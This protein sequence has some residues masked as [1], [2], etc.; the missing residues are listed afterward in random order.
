MAA[1]KGTI[2]LC[3]IV[4]DEEKNLARCLKSALGYVDEIIVVDTG[5]RDATPDIAKSYGAVV[6]HSPWQNDFSQARNESIK[7]AAGEWVLILDADEELPAETAHKLRDLARAP[8]VE[9]WT[10]TIVS[11]VLSRKDGPKTKHLNLRMFRNKDIYRFEGK[12]HEQVKPSILR[13]NPGAVIE[14]SNLAIIHYGYVRD[15]GERRAKTRRNIAILEEA[16]ASNPADPFYHYN[17]GV[18]YFTLGDLKSS[19]RHYETALQHADLKAGFAAVLYRNYCLCLYELGEYAETL[20]TADKALIYFADY[21]DLYFI[22]G[23]VFCDLGMLPE[24]KASFLKCT[25][26]RKIPPEYTTMEGVTSYLAFENLAEICALE[27]NWDEAVDHITRAIEHQ[28]S[29]RLLSRLC[30]LLQKKNYQGN[31]IA[32]YLLESLKIK[33]QTAARILFD[34]QEFEACLACIGDTPAGSE[35]ALLKA[36]CLIRLGHY[37]KAAEALQKIHPRCH[38]VVEG[39]KQKSLTAWLRNPR[40]DAAMPASAGNNPGHPATVCCQAINSL[41]GSTATLQQQDVREHALDIALEALRL[42]DR[43]LSMMISLTVT[44]HKI[45]EAYRTLG[46]YV[47]QKGCYAEAKEL[48]KQALN[49]GSATKEIYYLLGTACANLNLHGKAFGY[50]LEAFKQAPENELFA[51]CALQSLV[52]ECLAFVIN[53]LNLEKNNAVLRQELFRLTSL[54]RKLQYCKEAV[55]SADRHSQPLHDCQKRGR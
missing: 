2:S 38:L 23:Q 25:R 36:K 49:S 9:A 47:L 33:R 29:Y 20:A 6:V 5:S 54:K 32:A 10:F 13:H 14:Y 44:G 45:Q 8:G 22:K 48:L 39:L 21:P 4:R 15:T 1:N 50:F 46:E 27:G 51:A 11:P 55:Y 53:G 52:N 24:A 17:L 40:R 34:A 41:I 43:D 26:F 3:L 28:P 7:H 42:G 30:S 37:R 16:L 12:I 18:S 35:M 31:A 19:R